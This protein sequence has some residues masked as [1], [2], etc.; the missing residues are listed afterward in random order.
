MAALGARS[1]RA[2]LS[3]AFRLLDKVKNGTYTKWQIVYNNRK[4][5][6]HFRSLGHP[7]IKSLSLREL[8]FRCSAPV[9]S[10]DLN[11]DLKGNVASKLVAYDAADNRKV[12]VASLK[13]TGVPSFVGRLA[14]AY[15]TSTSCTVAG[16]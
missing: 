8:D 6:V 7:S 13:E 15:P 2:E 9:L 16:R 5:R 11:S 12:V 14:A 10:M 4:K 3:S 1:Q